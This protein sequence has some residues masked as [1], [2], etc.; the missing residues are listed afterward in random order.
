[1]DWLTVEPTGGEI[2]GGESL[3]LTVTADS[4]GL[5][6]GDY[7]V[8]ICVNTN[9]PEQPQISVQVD[10]TVGLP[11]SFGTVE[12]LVRSQG[13]CGAEQA[14][15][16]G[17]EIVVESQAETYTVF[18]D[19]D[20]FYEL[21]LEAAEG[22]VDVTATSPGHLS[23]TAFG[24][25]LVA[26]ETVTQDFDLI[27]EQPCATVEPAAFV[28]E[29]PEGAEETL[30]LTIGNVDGGATLEWAVASAVPLAADD[31]YRPSKPAGDVIS[32][33]RKA[34]GMPITASFARGTGSVFSETE[35]LLA[36]GDLQLSQTG[37]TN[38]VPAHSIACPTGPNHL[39]RRFYF[40]EHPG[41]GNPAEISSVD[42]AIL[43][44]IASQTL[45]VNLYTLPHGTPAD[46]PGGVAVPDRRRLGD[47][48]ACRRRH[49]R[50]R[51]GECHG[52]RHRGPR[53]GGRGHGGGSLLH[54]RHRHGRDPSRLHPGAGLRLQHSNAHRFARPGLRGH[55]HHHGRQR[56][57]SQ[58]LRQSDD[59]ALAERGPGGGQRRC[60]RN[61]SHLCDGRRQ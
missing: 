42:I 25:E 8:R 19:Q 46:H 29:L 31:P 22:P 9:D 33:W 53:P 57:R 16:T 1:V 49:Q 28:V 37:D 6:P 3:E 38:I 2:P 17:A 48:L 45:T 52:Q 44:G 14:P 51:A 15:I 5:A 56:R 61:R 40:D 47:H 26:G 4:S 34:A 41:V 60:G 35:D 12:G 24:V 32:T 43:Q 7:L 30:D 39:L 23:Q 10:L 36:L 50:Q 54:R 20:G 58:C 21:A 59:G 18:A 11:A 27:L 13:Y 55:P